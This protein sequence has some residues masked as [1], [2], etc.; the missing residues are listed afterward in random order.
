MLSEK[1]I[2]QILSYLTKDS[3]YELGDGLGYLMPSTRNTKDILISNI[4]DIKTT[5][6]RILK[7][8]TKANLQTICAALNILFD[9]LVKDQLIKE[10]QLYFLELNKSPEIT[11]KS[12]APKPPLKVKEIEV[13]ALDKKPNINIE[14][15][16]QGTKKILVNTDRVI[17][18]I[19]GADIN[20][21]LYFEKTEPVLTRR[22]YQ[23]I[24]MTYPDSEKEYSIGGS[25]QSNID[26]HVTDDQKFKYIG[27][28]IKKFSSLD[29]TPEI[30]RILGQT[31]MYKSDKYKN[32][33]L[34]ML[35]F[36][37]ENEY[38]EKRSKI[39]NIEKLIKQLGAIPVIKRL[40]EKT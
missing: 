27:I 30:H 8:M 16:K 12:I 3:I 40:K 24:V 37:T 33:D 17:D 11:E 13:K 25:Y 10:I 35:L 21:V 38:Q 18:I 29:K 7:Q 34:I 23:E 26:I 32:A 28:E 36:C 1:Q 19:L 2:R 14:S 15:M 5:E 9:G 31:I 6:N 20:Y 39:N 22:I 4:I